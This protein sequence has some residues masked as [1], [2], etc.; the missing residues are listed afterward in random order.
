MPSARIVPVEI[1]F[2]MMREVRIRR[3]IDL[4]VVQSLALQQCLGA[5]APGAVV[6]G[7]D[8]DVFHRA[9]SSVVDE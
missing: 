8:F 6:G 3:N 2:R 7:I 5:H 9:V 1:R 4:L